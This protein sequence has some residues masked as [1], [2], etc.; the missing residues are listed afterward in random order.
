MSAVDAIGNVTV[1]VGIVVATGT[2]GV[3]S[4][5]G[6]IVGVAS[7]VAVGIARNVTVTLGGGPTN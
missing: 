4:S 1:A 6:A 2:P 3:S 5:T 7:G